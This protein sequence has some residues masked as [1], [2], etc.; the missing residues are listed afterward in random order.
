M[1]FVAEAEHLIKRLYGPISPSE[2]PP[3]EK[4]ILELQH[5]HGWD[6]ANALLHNNDQNVRFIGCRTYQV[7]INDSGSSLD[8]PHL[9]SLLTKLLDWFMHCVE[10]NDSPLVLKKLCSTLVTYFVLSNATWTTAIRH[11]L[12]CLQSRRALPM[13]TLEGFPPTKDL[14]LLLRPVQLQLL[15]IFVTDLAIDAAKIDHTQQSDVTHRR[16][17]TNL[18]DALA[19]I[20]YNLDGAAEQT[21]DSLGD[22]LKCYGAWL[23]Y[24]RQEYTTSSDEM[25]KLRHTFGK[26]IQCLAFEELFESVAEFLIEQFTGGETFLTEA[27]TREFAAL[28]AGPWAHN[29][30]SRLEKDADYEAMAFAQLVLSFGETSARFVLKDLNYYAHI[31]EMAHRITR[32]QDVNEIDQ[33]LCNLVVDYWETM[34]SMADSIDRVDS[35]LCL[36]GTDWMHAIVELCFAIILPIDDNG[37]FKTYKHDDLIADFRYRVRDVILDSFSRFG[38]VVLSKLITMAIDCFNVEKPPYC[39]PMIESIFYCLNGMPESLDTSGKEDIVVSQL[40]TSQ[41][42][43][44]LVDFD[45]PIPTSTLR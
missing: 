22:T 1:S 30:M 38:V 20:E 11:V 19:I 23:A 43:E 18:N 32:T 45:K 17:G 7:A 4:R 5:A 44:D 37:E 35:G 6:L 10:G 21:A 27:E 31:M 15:M 42:Y 33:A 39:W 8:E 16:I 29:L 12:C 14:L 28:L 26:V 41:I 25:Q 24:G 9:D 13:Q 40:F 34:T 3:I 36:I 2:V